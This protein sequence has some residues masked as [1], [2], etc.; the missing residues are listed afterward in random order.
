MEIINQILCKV[1]HRVPFRFIDEIIKVDE[2]HIIGTCFLDEKSFYY[3]GHFPEHPITPGFIVA[4]VMA[5]IGILGLGIY[6]TLDYDYA[7]KTALLTSSEIKFHNVSYPND[8]IVVKS[9]KLFFRFNKL[10]CFIS[11]SNEKGDSICSGFMSGII[12]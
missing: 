10:K 9:E 5:Q 7:I 6:L 11:A 2:N 4:E 12:K 3:Q 1:P 8:I